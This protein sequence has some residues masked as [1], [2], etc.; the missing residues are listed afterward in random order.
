[1]EQCRLFS[2]PFEDVRY[3]YIVFGILLAIS[4]AATAHLFRS[5][6]DH[7]KGLLRA[8]IIILNLLGIAKFIYLLIYTFEYPNSN[9]MRI[10]MEIE[11]SAMIVDL[12]FFYNMYKMKIVEIYLDE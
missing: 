6:N 4:L 12:I 10:A 7:V 3:L 1:M 8:S 5:Y 11:Q 2:I 9:E